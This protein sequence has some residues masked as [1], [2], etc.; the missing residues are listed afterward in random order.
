MSDD[1][2][3][4]NELSKKQL[5]KT[6][7]LTVNET[8][9]TSPEGGN[10]HYIVLDARDWC[11]VIPET[12]DVFLMVKQWRHG[13]KCLS[14][15]FPGG[16]IDD[17]ETPLE[18]AHR[19]LKEETGYVTDNMI[20][21]GSMSPNPALFSNKMHFFLATNLK[22]TGQLDL[23]DDEYVNA[24]KVSKKEVFEKMGTQEYPHALMAAALNFYRQYKE[25][26]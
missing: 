18:A 3:I 1:K 2:L 15:E 11:A 13:S 26:H 20:Y 17:G 4:W 24:F 21:L 14:I 23:D 12:N 9:S 8:D 19:E 16:V 7:V 22:S 25:T 10:G 6:P 5:L